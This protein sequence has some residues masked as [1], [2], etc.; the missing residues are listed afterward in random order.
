MFYSIF[1]GNKLDLDNPGPN[2]PSSLLL[3][4]D[5]SNATNYLPSIA[6]AAAAAA[7]AAN[8]VNNSNNNGNFNQLLKI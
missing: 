8:S 4:L 3:A 1:G 2:A 5:P 6:L 7:A